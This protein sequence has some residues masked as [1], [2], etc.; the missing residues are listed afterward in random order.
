MEDY[1]TLEARWPRRPRVRQ[2][3]ERPWRERA[4]EAITAA[5]A[6][7]KEL[8]LEGRALELH[9]SRKGYPFGE[10]CNHPYRVWLHEY[11]RIVHGT[12]VPFDPRARKARAAKHGPAPGQ[13]AL[14][15]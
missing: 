12:R 8:G 6:A 4:H 1:P 2:P 7:A 13:L 5:I 10:R 11:H 14:F 15:T 9:V 3:Q